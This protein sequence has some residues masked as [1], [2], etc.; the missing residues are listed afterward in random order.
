M[1]SMVVENRVE[2]GGRVVCSN[3]CRPK[4]GRNDRK[5]RHPSQC[6]LTDLGRFLAPVCWYATRLRVAW[7]HH[8][9]SCGRWIPTIALG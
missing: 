2:Q 9:P 4:R 8:L 5:R 1:L 7:V 3:W 6:N